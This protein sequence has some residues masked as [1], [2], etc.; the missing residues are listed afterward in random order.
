M[1]DKDELEGSIPGYASIFAL[2]TCLLPAIK[3][4]E[5]LGHGAEY[6]DAQDNIA[7]VRVSILK[8]SVHACLA[9]PA[10]TSI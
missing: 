10:S 3:M 9:F 6:V 8:A 2:R 1:R 5:Y 4:A 7:D